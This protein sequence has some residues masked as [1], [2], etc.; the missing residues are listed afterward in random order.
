MEPGGFVS[1]LLH[2]DTNAL[3][4]LADPAGSVVRHRFSAP[5][6]SGAARRIS[7]ATPYVKPL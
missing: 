1:S 4:A 3:I 5:Q 6:R 7:V 2:V